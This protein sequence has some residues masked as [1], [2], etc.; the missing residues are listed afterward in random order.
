MLDRPGRLREP[1]LVSY[2][3]HHQQLHNE[4]NGNYGGRDSQSHGSIRQRR[5]CD[6][7]GKHRRHQ[8]NGCYYNYLGL[9]IYTLT[10]TNSAGV[11]ISQAVTV[12]VNPAAPIGLT[13][14]VGNATV[15]L[16]WTASTGAT[17]CNVYR[18]TTSG[19][20]STT[21]IATCITTTAYSDTGL[22]NGTTYYYKVA[23]V[24]GGGTSGYSNEASATPTTTSPTW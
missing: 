22:T 13:A 3:A 15:A 21:P 23:A 2:R 9:T 8:R 6:Y 12:T 10:V 20:D 24:N 7:A 11:T 18:G 4:S 5:G 16:S 19:G 14:T 17:S 1:G